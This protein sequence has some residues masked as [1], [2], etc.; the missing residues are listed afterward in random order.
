ML[1]L[2]ISVLLSFGFSYGD[3]GKIVGSTNYNK[4][5]VIQQVK[6]SADYQALGGDDALDAIVIGDNVD[7]RQ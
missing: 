5:E 2:L 7:P 4:Q 6:N 3:Q 1:Q